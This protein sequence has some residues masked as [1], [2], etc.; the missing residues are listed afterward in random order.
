MT[1]RRITSFLAGVATL[2]VAT[3]AHA[4]GTLS[5]QGFGYPTGGMSARALGAGGAIT[6]FDPLSST[7][8]RRA[9]EH[10]RRRVVRPGGARVPPAVRRRRA[11]SRR[12][13]RAIRWRCVAI[14]LRNNLMAGLT[15]SNLLDR[16]FETNE[17]R[18][19]I[20]GDSTLHHD[21]FLQERRRHRRRARS[22]LAW[23]PANWIRLGVAGHAITGD[24]RLRS[25]QQF[26]D[27]LRFASIVDTSTVDVR[28][29]RRVGG[30]LAVPRQRRGRGGLVSEGRLDVGEACRHDAG[31]GERSRS[32][33]VQRR[34]RR[35]PWHDHRRANLEGHLDAHARARLAHASDQRGLGHE[36][37]RGRARS[38]LGTAFHPAARRR[39]VAHAPLRAGDVGGE[40]EELRRSASARCSHAAGSHSTSR[41]S[42]RCATRCPAR[43]ICTRR[44]GRSASGLTVRP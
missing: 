6:E 9:A 13:S 28:R 43:S 22:P 32:H 17:R 3:A 21:Q 25:T 31:Q 29:H 42:G 23:A 34:L 36:R 35:H 20:I 40:G 1:T 2:A 11:R 24:N 7:Q 39:A 38:P 12:A 15:V 27:S 37:R 8:S 4:Q 44:R 41:G 18:T 16:S 14:P 5:T 33:V 19:Q 10:R 30:R 26:D